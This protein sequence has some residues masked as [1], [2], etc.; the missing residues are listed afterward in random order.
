MTLNIRQNCASRNRAPSFNKEKN[1]VQVQIR[2]TAGGAYP[3]EGPLLIRRLRYAHFILHYSGYAFC[4]FDSQIG[5]GS[6]EK[7]LYR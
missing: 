3:V 1:A 2:A 4:P 6:P 7:C 5:S